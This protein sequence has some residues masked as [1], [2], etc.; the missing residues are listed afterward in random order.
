MVVREMPFVVVVE[1]EQEKRSKLRTT[2]RDREKAVKDG[3]N[4]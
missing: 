4:D 1:L 2:E 3:V